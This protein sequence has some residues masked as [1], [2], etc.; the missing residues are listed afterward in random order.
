MIRIDNHVITPCRPIMRDVPTIPWVIISLH[1]FPAWT[2]I[3][4]QELNPWV[5]V[6]GHVNGERL[7]ASRVKVVIVE[8][9]I[10]ACSV[11][12]SGTKRAIGLVGVVVRF[13][14]IRPGPACQRHLEYRR[15]KD[16]AIGQ[17]V[18]FVDYAHCMFFSRH[19]DRVSR[20][21]T[22]VVVCSAPAGDVP[23]VVRIGRYLNDCLAPVE[24]G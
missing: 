15:Q 14:L 4:E 21:R 23:A 20:A 16:S 7:C 11:S 13:R 9:I 22:T 1:R 19:R 12:L 18:P 2:L 8:L 24:V 6:V 17:A 3:I 10:W 5:G